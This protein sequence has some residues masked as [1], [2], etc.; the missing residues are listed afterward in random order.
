MLNCKIIS[1]TLNETRSQNLNCTR[2]KVERILGQREMAQRT[3]WMTGLSSTGAGGSR[4]LPLL[5]CSSLKY[6][7]EEPS[8]NS[9]TVRKLSSYGDCN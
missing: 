4:G 3:G 9:L 5:E 7:E 2:P 6:L 1:S 8:D